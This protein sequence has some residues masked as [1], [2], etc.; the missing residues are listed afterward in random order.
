MTN[1]EIEGLP[2]KNTLQ[3]KSSKNSF[4]VA[5]GSSRTE[6]RRKWPPK[7][8]CRSALSRRDRRC[9]EL[10]K[11]QESFE[12][13]GTRRGRTLLKVAPGQR[14][15]KSEKMERGGLFIGKAQKGKHSDFGPKFQAHECF[16]HRKRAHGGPCDQHLNQTRRDACPEHR[17]ASAQ[18]LGRCRVYRRR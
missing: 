10:L 9:R 6:L 4:G 17:T 11:S 1:T 2:L 3:Q 18:P 15:K 16:G 14:S 12:R 7:K 5:Q 13:W 8:K